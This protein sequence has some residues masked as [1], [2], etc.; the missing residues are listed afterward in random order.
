MGLTSKGRPYYPPCM[1][2]MAP[3]CAPRTPTAWAFSLVS[4]ALGVA[5]PGQGGA[6]GET[7]TKKEIVNINSYF[8]TSFGLLDSNSL[9]FTTTVRFVC[10]T[11]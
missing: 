3:P 1:E 11:I 10:V 7:K 4:K 8:G 6:T 9:L 5:Q 2:E